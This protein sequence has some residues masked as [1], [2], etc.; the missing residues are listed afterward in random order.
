MIS[1]RYLPEPFLWYLFNQMAKALVILQFGSI[2]TN[3]AGLLR[4]DDPSEDPTEGP[5]TNSP[6]DP[7]A[8]TTSGTSH[9]RNTPLTGASQPA[10]TPSAQ[11]PPA[12]Y[13]DITDRIVLIKMC[14]DNGIV[15]PRKGSNRVWLRKQLMSYDKTHQQTQL[16]LQQQSSSVEAQNMT[17]LQ[18][19]VDAKPADTLRRVQTLR[20]HQARQEA[21][22]ITLA[23]RLELATTTPWREIGQSYMFSIL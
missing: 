5:P 20:M 22:Q 13:E 19:Q 11:L 17:N 6:Q 1:R 8:G 15:V 7:Q 10:T 4:R 18:G 21:I 9:Q 12:D 2:P 3:A 16:R 23:N 14:K